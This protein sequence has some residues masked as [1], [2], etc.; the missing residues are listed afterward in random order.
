ML[1]YTTD[2]GLLIKFSLPVCQSQHF[3]PKISCDFHAC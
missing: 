1:V 3:F 2:G